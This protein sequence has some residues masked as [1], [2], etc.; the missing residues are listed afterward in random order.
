MNEYELCVLFSGQQTQEETDELAKQVEEL[1]KSAEAEV[2]FNHSLG[3]KKLAYAIKTQTHGEY[4][5][6]LFSA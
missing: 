5:C 6:W 1:L 4:R 3:R 2:V